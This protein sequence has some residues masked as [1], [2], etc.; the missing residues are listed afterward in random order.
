M[1]FWRGLEKRS[2]CIRFFLKSWW[3]EWNFF[4]LPDRLCSM[5]WTRNYSLL[6]PSVGHST[7]MYSLS[8]EH[9]YIHPSLKFFKMLIK[10]W[11]IWSK[12]FQG[13]SEQRTFCATASPPGRFF[14]TVIFVWTGSEILPYPPRLPWK[15]LGETVPDTPHRIPPRISIDNW[16]FEERYI[17]ANGLSIQVNFVT[18]VNKQSSHFFVSL[19]WWMTPTQIPSVSKVHFSIMIILL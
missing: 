5:E 6:L 8:L 12:I 18:Q 7:K 9:M 13:R 10:K 2:C 15:V 4:S 3:T 14:H 17:S 19:T 11:T 16:I 1:I